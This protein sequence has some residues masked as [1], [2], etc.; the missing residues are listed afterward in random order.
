MV[1]FTEQWLKE[2][3]TK[4]S[5]ID[6]FK[7]VSNFSKIS[8]ELEGSRIYVRKY[9]QNTEVNYFQRISKEK[10]FEMTVTELLE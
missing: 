1:C 2:E 7:L 6:H 5:Y 3:Q 4:L 8:S 9:L 10:D